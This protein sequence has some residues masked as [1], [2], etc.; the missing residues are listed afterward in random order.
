MKKLQFI[1]LK[2]ISENE[3]K[4]GSEIYK[5]IE[6]KVGWTEF[7][8]IQSEFMKNLVLD[9]YSGNKLTELGKNRLK[10]LKIE[11]EQEKIDKE[12]ERKKLHNESIMSGWKRKTFWYIFALGLFGG[13]YSAYDL[14]NK[15]TS[16][17]EI[18]IE[19]ITK[20][21]MEEELSKLRTLILTQKK[22]DSLKIPNSE[23]NK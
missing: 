5:L 9:S 2:T 11:L 7:H 16:S 23:L 10:D 17:K 20:Q 21:E 15:I 22:G 1:L 14:F 8:K 13:I 6:D 19:Q 3:N 4:S 18:P 12:A